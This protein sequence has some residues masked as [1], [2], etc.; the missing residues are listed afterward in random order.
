MIYVFLFSQEMGYCV[1]H[2][3]IQVLAADRYGAPLSLTGTAVLIIN[4]DDVNDNPP[5][6]DQ[7][8]YSVNVSEALSSGV[9]IGEF[10]AHDLDLSP[11]NRLQYS[12]IDGADGR[13][14]MDRVTGEKCKAKSTQMALYDCQSVILLSLSAT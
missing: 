2:D 3:L 11:N 5:T 9:V 7:D 14:W 4:I 10:M 1:T 13:F 8:H 12:I 6:F